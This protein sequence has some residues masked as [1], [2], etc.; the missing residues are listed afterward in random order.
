MAVA[1]LT[2][3]N[4][5]ALLQPASFINSK[6]ISLSWIGVLAHLQWQKSHV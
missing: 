3:F 6:N 2:L 1:G 4:P 5:L